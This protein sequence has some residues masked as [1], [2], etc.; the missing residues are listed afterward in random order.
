M[1][2]TATARIPS[3]P[4]RAFLGGSATA[5]ALGAFAATG[6]ARQGTAHARPGDGEAGTSASS[7]VPMTVGRGMADMTGEPLGAGMNG[8]AV[9]EQQTSGLRQRDRKSVV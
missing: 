2:D 5:A 1:T 8:Y 6:L 7:T 3:I 9:L 4:R